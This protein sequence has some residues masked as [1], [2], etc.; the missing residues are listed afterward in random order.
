MRNIIVSQF[1]SAAMYKSFND[2]FFVLYPN[3]KFTKKLS[4][5]NNK[6]L[7]SHFALYTSDISIIARFFVWIFYPAI[8]CVLSVTLT[9]YIS[10]SAAGSGIPEMKT[11]LRSPSVHKDYVSWR[12][13]IAKLIG[14]ILALGSR[15]PGKN[16]YFKNWVSNI[17]VVWFTSI[18]TPYVKKI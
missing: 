3:L 11:I 6:I 7:E 15:L 10:P 17:C 12:V 4:F 9:R 14:L 13:M 5:Y 8:L 18:M 1:P 16:R 2:P